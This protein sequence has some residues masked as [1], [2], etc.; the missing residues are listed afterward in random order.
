MF[1][2]G[3][4]KVLNMRKARHHERENS[5]RRIKKSKAMSDVSANLKIKSEKPRAQKKAV[6]PFFYFDENILAETV[7]ETAQ[8]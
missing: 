4:N 3:E 2:R 5:S 1:F 8:R 6:K 7:V